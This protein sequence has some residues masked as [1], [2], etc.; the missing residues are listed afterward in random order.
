MTQEAVP[1]LNADAARERRRNARGE[2]QCAKGAA[3]L[4]ARVRPGGPADAVAVRVNGALHGL[5]PLCLL[6]VGWQA[7]GKGPLLAFDNDPA[8]AIRQA[9]GLDLSREGGGHQRAR[10]RG[11]AVA[12]GSAVGEESR[13]LQSRARTV[14]PLRLT[15]RGA[16]YCVTRPDCSRAYSKRSENCGECRET[17]QQ[18]HKRHVVVVAR[19]TASTGRTRNTMRGCGPRL[20]IF[21]RC[22]SLMSI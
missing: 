14:M 9:L 19:A 22:A 2:G 10:G 4:T 20:H 16:T 5:D 21:F 8:V 17:C 13:A 6:A 12:Q 11:W 3:P 1:E 18:R 7:E 15:V